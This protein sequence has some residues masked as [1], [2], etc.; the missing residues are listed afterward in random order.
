MLE[1]AF[2]CSPFL[3]SQITIQDDK[4]GYDRQLKHQ[5]KTFSGKDFIPN[6]GNFMLVANMWHVKE[7]KTCYFAAKSLSVR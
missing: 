5:S 6:L 1:S 7:G 4:A 3:F 2:K